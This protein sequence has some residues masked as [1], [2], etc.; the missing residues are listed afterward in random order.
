MHPSMNALL[1][2]AVVVFCRP[3]VVA[4]VS[5]PPTQAFFV[6]IKLHMKVG[7]ALQFTESVR[8]TNVYTFKAAAALTHQYV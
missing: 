5:L 1:Q 3:L 8:M 7:P 6:L 2:L 4:E